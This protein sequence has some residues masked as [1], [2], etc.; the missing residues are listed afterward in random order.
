[1]Y[2][3]SKLDPENIPRHIAIIMD[4]NGRWAK[5]KGLPR[6]LGHKAG[7]KTV[8]K[9]V[10]AA[11]E[12][13]VSVLT[14]YAFSTENWKRP[15]REVQA[16]MTLLK[17]FLKA[18]RV[19]MLRN[20]II[21]RCIGEIEGF[22]T[23]VKRLLHEVGKE[24]KENAGQNEGMILNLALNYGG[25]AEIVMAARSMAEKCLKGEISLND[26]S[27]ELFAKHLYT[28]DIADPDIVIR[29]GGD[30]RLSNFLLWQV[31]YSELYMTDIK[32]PDFNKECL[33][34]A[35]YNYQSRERRF[36]RTSAQ[37]RAQ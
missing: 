11:R 26:F 9:I 10:T 4:G 29:T 15:Q 5:Q 14:L 19:N 23:D 22:S 16:L 6:V 32:W 33:L 17:T 13:G 31:S 27:E 20:K 28:G 34:E 2:D 7:T 24:T 8:K 1:M 35:L 12:I 3:I 25:R 21:L 36:G 37:A 18:E 30:S